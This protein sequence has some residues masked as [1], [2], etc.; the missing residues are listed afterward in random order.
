MSETYLPFEFAL[1]HSGTGEAPAWKFE[2]GLVQ[3]RVSLTTLEEA[4]DGADRR[5]PDEIYEE[6]KGQIKTAAA[7]KI[8]DSEG[9]FEEPVTVTSDDLRRAHT[10]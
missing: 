7:A 2:R 8:E 6:L 9:L 4:W 3:G 1:S 10:V 5:R